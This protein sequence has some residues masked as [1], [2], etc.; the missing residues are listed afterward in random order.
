[1]FFR[2]RKTNRQVFGF[3]CDEALAQRVRIL[4]HLIEV[5][6]YTLCEHLFQL[7]LGH[8]GAEIANNRGNVR[9]VRE[10]L[11]KHL[12]DHH[13]LVQKLGSE[14]YEQ[15]I[16][17]KHVKLTAEQKEQVKAVIDLVLRFETDGTPYQVVLQAVERLVAR[18]ER[19][20]RVREAQRHRD[21]QMLQRINQRFP[22]LLPALRELMAKY[23]AEELTNALSA[24]ER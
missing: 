3:L 14:K 8:I 16:I 1:M 11:K 24:S 6:I 4:A 18:L 20:H 12:L 10:E 15:R 19:R 22:R 21:F 23:S 7:G 9:L 5:P 13:L 17:A 2:K